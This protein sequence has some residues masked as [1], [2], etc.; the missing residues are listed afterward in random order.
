MSAS[1]IPN[2]ATVAEEGR[3]GSDMLSGEES[4]QTMARRGRDAQGR[5]GMLAGNQTKLKVGVERP[6]KG[7]NLPQMWKRGS[8]GPG[9]RTT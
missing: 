2:G 3:V 7:G 6:E 8:L 9:L 4:W 5:L 1:I